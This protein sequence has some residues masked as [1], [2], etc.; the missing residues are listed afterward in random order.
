MRALVKVDQGYG[1]LEV[2]EVQDPQIAA[3]QVLIK[4]KAAGICGSDVKHYRGATKIRTPIILGHEFSGEIVEVGEEAGD[5]SEGGRV[6]SETSAHVCGRCFYCRTGDYHLCTER[7]GLG[8]GVDGAF[9]E[10]VAVPARLLHRIPDGLSY[11][12]TTLIQ[13]CADVV[14]AVFRKA[15]IF[16]GDTV[17]V[18]GPGPMG[19]L[20]T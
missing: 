3:D 20:T 1:N 16:P 11:E 15:E 7:K 4:V 12:E 8:S 5:W 10:Y 2:R 6:T 13:P 17:V 19:L 18:L 14:N 9:A